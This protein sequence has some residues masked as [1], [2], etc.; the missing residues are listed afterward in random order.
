ML[1]RRGFM[2]PVAYHQ[3]LSSRGQHSSRSL[4]TLGFFSIRMIGFL[5]LAILAL[6]YVAQSSQGATKRIQVQSLRAQA[7]T[8]V[9]EEDQLRLEA[10][11]LQS[12]DTISQSVDQ[13]QLEPVQSV[14]F[15]SQ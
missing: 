8:L 14:E 12:L 7:D 11:R 10:K 3:S 1:I 2:V 6:M 4:V 13:M 9:T 15:L 5:V